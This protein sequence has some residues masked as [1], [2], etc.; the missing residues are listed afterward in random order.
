MCIRDSPWVL[1][2]GRLNNCG[3]EGHVKDLYADIFDNWSARYAEEAK[4]NPHAAADAYLMHA[5]GFDI[6]K[7]RGSYTQETYHDREKGITSATVRFPVART[8]WERL[9]DQ[10][11][12]FG[13]KKARFQYGGSYLGEWWTP[14]GFDIAKVSELWLVEGIF[15]AIALWSVGVHAVSYTHLDVYKRQ[16]VEALDFERILE[17]RKARYIALFAQDE[18]SAVAK[19]LALESEPLT[20]LLQENSEREVILRQRVNEAARAVLLAFAQKADLEHIAAEYGV[21]RLVIKPADTSTIPPTDAIYESDDA[22]RERAQMAWEGL[23]TACLL[24]TSRCV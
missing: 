21:R 12:R 24:Y 18:Q 14:P 17:E 5:R 3:Y 13:K 10:P 22:L 19:A 20:I 1:R 16:V 7:L 2:C 11:S 23:S 8:Y 15:D 9:I 4:T 6:S